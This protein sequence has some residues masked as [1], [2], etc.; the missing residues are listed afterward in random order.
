MKVATSDPFLAAR[1]RDHVFVTDL[2]ASTT[3]GL[4]FW[5]PSHRYISLTPSKN[6]GGLVELMDNNPLV[7]SDAAWVPDAASTLLLIG[8]GPIAQAG[9]A[10]EPPSIQ[11]NAPIDDDL[12]EIALKSVDWHEEVTAI[13][14]EQ[15][16]DGIYAMTVISKFKNPGSWDDLDDLFDERYSRSL[17]VR[18]DDES[19]WSTALVKDKPWAVYRLRLTQ[20]EEFSLLTCQVMADPN[21]KCGSAQIIHMMNVM[22]GFEESVG[23]L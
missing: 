16:L 1:L 7:C 3:P 11:T 22:C 6:L 9:I 19:E 23:I 15:D 2:E 18:K 21:G 20:G 14:Q 13:H 5:S 8:F 17:F 12:I 4:E 10:I